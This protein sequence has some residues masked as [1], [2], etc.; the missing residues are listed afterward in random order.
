MALRIHLNNSI[1]Q[2][3]NNSMVSRFPPHRPN[4]RQRVA[5]HRPAVFEHRVH[6]AHAGRVSRPRHRVGHFEL[7]EPAHQ[8]PRAVP[9]RPDFVVLKPHHYSLD[10]NPYRRTTGVIAA[11]P[12][13]TSSVATPPV[14]I[15]IAAPNA[16]GRNRLATKPA[17]ASPSCGPPIKKIMFIAVMRPRSASGVSTWRSVWR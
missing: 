2:S 5:L 3:P 6:Q 10:A 14:A 15:E 1:T 9:H 13:T 17:S 4:L 7:A 12:A 16:A 8:F 11:T